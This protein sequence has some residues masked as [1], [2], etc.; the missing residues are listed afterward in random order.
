METIPNAI[1]PITKTEAD[2][3]DEKEFEEAMRLF[4]L[5]IRKKEEKKDGE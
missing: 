1:E 5:P 4:G 2:E 3:H